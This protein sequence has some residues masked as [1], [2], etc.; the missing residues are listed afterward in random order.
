[1]F[2]ERKDELTE[3]LLIGDWS[4]LIVLCF[5][6]GKRFAPISLS[7]S[8]GRYEGQAI[9]CYRRDR[10]NGLPHGGFDCIA[11]NK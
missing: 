1:M 11:T 3:K 4:R 2:N 7:L 9:S 10:Q 5:T 8:C 6:G